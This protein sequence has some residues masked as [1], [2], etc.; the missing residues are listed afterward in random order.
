MEIKHMRHEDDRLFSKDAIYY[1]KRCNFLAKENVRLNK[2]IE[3][4]LE[5]KPT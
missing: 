1:E 2:L 3:R 4:I 5:I